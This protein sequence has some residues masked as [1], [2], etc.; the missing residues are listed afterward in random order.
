MTQRLDIERTFH[1]DNLL[2]VRQRNRI[3]KFTA[4]IGHRA[5]AYFWSEIEKAASR[6]KHCRDVKILDYGCG[7]GSLAQKLTQMG[8]GAVS[9]IDISEGMIQRARQ[10]VPAA[11]F[12]VMNG[13][14]LHFPDGHFDIIIGMAI[15]HHLDLKKAS[16]EIARV[17]KPEGT[18][19][20]FE[21]LGHNPAINLF[22]KLTPGA[23][24]RFEEPLKSQ[25]FLTLKKT[26]AQVEQREFIFLV[27]LLLPLRPVLPERIFWV[28]ESG[29]AKIDAWLWHRMPF[30]R[31]YYWI[32]VVT[33]CSARSGPS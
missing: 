19:I 18:A 17:L 26:F 6:L 32:T 33:L 8:V 5:D 30:L 25:H 12:L 15:L 28:L 27:L 1:D 13:E 2:R 9:G 22:R 10:R 23:R 21:P 24:T 20:F 3:A 29:L 11:T 7:E 31:K 4:G 16:C 14:E